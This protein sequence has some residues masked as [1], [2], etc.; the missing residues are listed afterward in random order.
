M[1]VASNPLI[2]VIP[3]LMIWTLISFGITLYVLKRYAFGPIQ[4]LI[5][6]RRE[7]I[8][9]SVEEADH[10]REEA[11]RLLE[12][13]RA[14]IG[15]ARSEAEAIL[16][17]AR[18]IAD[19]QRERMRAETE[20]DRQR[21]LEETG[22]QDRTGDPAGT[23]RDPPRKVAISPLAAEKITRKTPTSD[24]AE[25][26]LI[27]EVLAEDRFL[28]IREPLIALAHRVMFSALY[29]A[30]QGKDSLAVVREE[31]ADLV[32]SLAE[33]PELDRLL[34]DREID[35]TVKV[36]V[37]QKVL[38]ASNPLPASKPAAPAEKGRAGETSTS[39]RVRS[40]RSAEERVLSVEVTTAKELSDRDFERILADIERKS[41]RKVQASRSV[42]P[43]LIGG[44]AVACWYR[45]ERAR[46][47]RPP[48]PG[49]RCRTM[50]TYPERQAPL[51]VG[52]RFP[53][54]RPND[55]RVLPCLAQGSRSP[56]SRRQGVTR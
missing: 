28:R 13:H 16:G 35:T 4:K 14:L 26:R 32:H 2:K 48:A 40:A 27:D 52:G 18:R 34:A 24:D 10:A 55:P 46:P 53:Q 21:R 54:R 49:T 29:Q 19:A 8:R 23:S 37:V 51:P 12:E 45:R 11:R 6:D 17:E 25:R 33:V 56:E 31:F 42:E 36:D 44:I 39:R 41:G 22:R 7:R 50:S 1:L 3:G 5:D 30:A 47:V 9:Q 38:A 15:Q 20:E 43:E